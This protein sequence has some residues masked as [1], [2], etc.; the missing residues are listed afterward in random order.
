M[1]TVQMKNSSRNDIEE[2]YPQFME[3][4]IFRWYLKLADIISD[5]K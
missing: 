1:E 5:V 4:I 2:N 3:I